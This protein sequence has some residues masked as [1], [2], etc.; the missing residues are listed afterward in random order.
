MFI[1]YAAVC[2]FLLLLIMW[3]VSLKWEVLYNSIDSQ[4]K[5]GWQLAINYGDLHLFGYHDW[6]ELG[7]Y[8]EPGLSFPSRKYPSSELNTNYFIRYD[9]W[10]E[11]Q[12]LDYEINIHLWIP[13]AILVLV[14]AMTFAFNRNQS[15]DAAT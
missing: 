13:M 1:R 9:S 11:S 12:E 2:A 7:Q 5:A 14:F 6:N 8:I 3:I 10:P 15:G 4:K